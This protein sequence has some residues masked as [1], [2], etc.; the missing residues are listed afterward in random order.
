MVSSGV[1]VGI[2]YAS[3]RLSQPARAAAEAAGARDDLE[4]NVFAEP[5][6]IDHKFIAS[7]ISISRDMIDR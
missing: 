7:S 6:G 4:P 2:L 5:A 3:L 1:S